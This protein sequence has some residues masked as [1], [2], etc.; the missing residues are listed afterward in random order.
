VNSELKPQPRTLVIE[1]DILHTK[2]Q[3]IDNSETD[4]EEPNCSRCADVG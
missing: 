3:R 1:R 2:V 4:R